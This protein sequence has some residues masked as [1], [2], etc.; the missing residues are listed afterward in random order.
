MHD[1]RV[2]NE[3]FDLLC[4]KCYS[5]LRKRVEMRE[6]EGENSPLDEGEFCEACDEW[7][8]VIGVHKR[9]F[10]RERDVAA[11]IDEVEDI[12]H[13]IEIVE[14]TGTNIISNADIR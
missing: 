5:V 3:W 11:E 1:S 2:E 14:I 12:T 4:S 10:R 6:I 13:G 9:E 7:V 8:F